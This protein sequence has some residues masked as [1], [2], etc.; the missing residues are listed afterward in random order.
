MRS[1]RDRDK[2]GG[3]DDTKSQKAAHQER[4]RKAREKSVFV[5][6]PCL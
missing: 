1:R 6:R 4:E 2:E 5:I 3:E